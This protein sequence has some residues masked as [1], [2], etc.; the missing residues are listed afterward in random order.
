MTATPN[1]AGGTSVHVVWDHTSRNLTAWLAIAMMRV[2]GPRY[3]A[4]YFKKV[5]DRL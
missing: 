4:Y 5:Y 3:L 2:I 1:T